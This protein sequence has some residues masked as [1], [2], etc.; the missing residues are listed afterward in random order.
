[1]WYYRNVVQAIGNAV[2]FIDN[3]N[4]ITTTKSLLLLSVESVRDLPTIT[5]RSGSIHGAS[6]VNTPATSERISR[7][8][9]LY[10]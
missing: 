10:L 7:V 1:M 6:T 8:M 4:E 5:G 2:Y 9:L 3:P